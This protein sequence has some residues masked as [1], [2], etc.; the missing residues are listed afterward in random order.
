MSYY[1]QAPQPVSRLLDSGFALYRHVFKPVLPLS[2]L[3]ALV[4]Q[5][6]QV[7]QGTLLAALTTGHDPAAL[8]ASDIG[9]MMVWLAPAWL[10]WLAFYSAAFNA[11]LFATD[12]LARGEPVPEIGS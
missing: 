12:A 9:S 5:V 1:P 11:L 7:A 10:V 2:A 8:G 3:L 4:S 6:P